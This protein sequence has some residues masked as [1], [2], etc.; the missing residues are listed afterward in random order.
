[1]R[2]IGDNSTQYGAPI[3]AGAL[4]LVGLLLLTFPRAIQRVALRSIA[5]GPTAQWK[6]LERFIASNAYIWNVRIVGLGAIVMGAFLLW[7]LRQ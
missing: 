6:W 4:L 1:M 5:Q 7:A 2:A 3:F